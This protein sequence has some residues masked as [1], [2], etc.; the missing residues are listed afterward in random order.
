MVKRQRLTSLVWR[1]IDERRHE[2]MFNIPTARC[3]IQK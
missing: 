1:L 3:E 2:A